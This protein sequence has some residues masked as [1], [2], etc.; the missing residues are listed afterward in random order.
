MKPFISLV[1]MRLFFPGEVYA[2]L[3]V[4]EFPEKVKFLIRDK[5]IKNVG[6]GVFIL[7]DLS[8]TCCFMGYPLSCRWALPTCDYLFY[9]AGNASSSSVSTLSIS[10]SI[11]TFP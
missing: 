3:V 1:W 2:T 5:E 10:S 6:G 8:V 11:F 9:D 4:D 7:Q